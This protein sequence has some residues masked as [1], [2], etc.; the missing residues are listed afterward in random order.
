MGMQK[1]LNRMVTGIPRLFSFNVNA[2]FICYFHSQI[3]ELRHI[4][5]EFIRNQY[6]VILSYILVTRHNHTINPLCIYL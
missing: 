1:T 3:F 6:M 5:K 4:F 2:N